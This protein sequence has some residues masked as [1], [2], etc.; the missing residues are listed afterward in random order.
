LFILA[1]GQCCLFAFP[2]VLAGTYMTANFAYYVFPYNWSMNL[3][4]TF[5]SILSATDPVVVAALMDSLGA[6]ERLKT[7][8]NGEALLNDGSAMVFF[9]IF[10]QRFLLELNNPEYG[11]E[12]DLPGGVALFCRKAIGGVAAG[13]LFGLILLFITYKFNRHFS[14]DD[15]VVEVAATFAI[16]YLGY[17]IADAVWSTSGVLATVTSGLMTTYFGRHN[18]L[19]VQLLD[20]FWSLVQFIL[21]TVL[22]TLGGAVWGGIIVTGTKHG[23]FGGIDWLYLLLLYVVLAAIRCA[24]FVLLYPI[25]VRIGLKTSIQETIFQIHGG[26]RGAVGIALAIYLNSITENASGNKYNEQTTKAFG[27]VGGIAFLTLIVNGITAGPLLNYLGLAETK[28]TRKSIIKSYEAGYV[29]AMLQKFMHLLTQKRFNTVNFDIVRQFVPSLQSLSREQFIDAIK[30]HNDN[31]PESQYIPPYIDRVLPYLPSNA[32]HEYQLSGRPS[33]TNT[34]ALEP[35]S[36][37]QLQ[38]NDGDYDDH[39]DDCLLTNTAIYDEHAFLDRNKCERKL[40][41]DRRTVCR[42]NNTCTGQSH[43][44]SDTL[45]H[46]MMQNDTVYAIEHRNIFLSIL[47]SAYRQQIVDGEIIPHEVLAIQGHPLHDWDHLRSM[48]QPLVN[49]ARFFRTKLWH[50]LVKWTKRKYEKR[51]LRSSLPISTALHLQHMERCLAFIAAHNYAQ[52]SFEKK[53]LLSEVELS[54]ASKIVIAE[55]KAQVAKAE[56]ELQQSLQ[57]YELE[58]L[59]SIKFCSI[60]LHSGIGY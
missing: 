13:V 24:L 39:Y 46:L 4:M 53:F 36:T 3:C 34:E 11:T 26:L 57:E 22:F 20:H 9:F 40:S 17:Y 43:T 56:H 38:D 48:D 10:I 15:T 59:S 25:T 60:L 44:Q 6:P 52:R 31:T 12:L 30:R 27:M 47:R 51:Q 41:I 21:N 58:A 14:S 7:H 50:A 23:T 45:I 1:L 19:N 8:I 18:F 5:G 37:I 42:R 29:D 49:F 54:E 32:T 28:T 16:A 55:S 33:Y 2:L 35:N